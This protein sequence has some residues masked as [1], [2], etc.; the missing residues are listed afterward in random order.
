VGRATIHKVPVDATLV[1]HATDRTLAQWTAIRQRL[2]LA[3][4]LA[5]GALVPNVTY[6]LF[7]LA[8]TGIEPNEVTDAV[9]I[10]LAPLQHDDG[11]WGGGADPR[12]PLSGGPVLL[13][14]LAIRALAAYAPPGRRDEANRRI[15]R[16]QQFLRTFPVDDTQDEVFR[17]LGLVWSGAAATEISASRARLLALQ[18]VDG[19]WG[20]R[21]ALTA[22]AYATGQAL[23]ALKTSGLAPSSSAYAK[24][25]QYLRDTQLED[26]TWHVRSRAVGLQAYFETGFPHGTDQFI[27]TA[28]TAWAAIALADALP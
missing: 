1:S 19:A 14:A 26:G 22:D 25:V 6:G 24:G 27:S 15:D 4:P 21:P 5:N 3:N 11:S 10:A 23:Y 13:T 9:T 17:L 12:P 28:A 16:A 20:Q 8:E 2:L 18:R 7:G